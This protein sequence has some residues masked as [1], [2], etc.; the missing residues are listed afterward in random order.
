MSDKEKKPL[1][2]GL[3]ALLFGGGGVI[4]GGVASSLLS[5]TSGVP[6]SAAPIAFLVIAGAGVIVGIIELVQHYT[7]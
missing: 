5:S 7:T 3:K 2:G 6:A 4:G 1:H